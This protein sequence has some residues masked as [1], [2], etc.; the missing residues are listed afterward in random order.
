MNYRNYKNFN[1]STFLKEIESTD[2]LID[3]N[4]LNEQYSHL[5]ETFLKVVNKYTPLIKKVV[6][7]NQAPCVNKEMRKAISTRTRLRNNF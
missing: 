3:S 2:F 6:R 7:E 4:G 5:T 1:Q